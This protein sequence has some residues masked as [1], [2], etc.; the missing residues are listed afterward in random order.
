[1][2]APERYVEPGAI[3]SGSISLLPEPIAQTFARLDFQAQED[4][5]EVDKIREDS[6]VV[7]RFALAS[8]D[9]ITP[10]EQLHLTLAQ[11]DQLIAAFATYAEGLYS[12]L[13]RD[14]LFLISSMAIADGVEDPDALQSYLRQ[15]PLVISKY[16]PGL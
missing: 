13:R 14:S 12:L 5:K 6:A 2:V 11:R 15:H 1:M 8:G 3:A 10:G 4:E 7:E 9:R 16:A